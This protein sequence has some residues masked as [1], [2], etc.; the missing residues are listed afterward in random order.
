MFAFLWGSRDAR[1]KSEGISGKDGKIPSTMVLHNHLYVSYTRFSTMAG[2]FAN[3]LLGKWLEVIRRGTYQIASEDI[4]WAY[5]P[6]SD[7]GMT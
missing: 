2:P 3:N 5:E 7:C 4:R 1:K 6:V